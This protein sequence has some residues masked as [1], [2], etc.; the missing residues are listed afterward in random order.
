MFAAKKSE[1]QSLLHTMYII[2]RSTFATPSPT[3][4]SDA[5]ERAK[6]T[7]VK[8]TMYTVYDLMTN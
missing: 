4:R 7:R 3:P 1:G 6:I 8:T 2:V 5:Y